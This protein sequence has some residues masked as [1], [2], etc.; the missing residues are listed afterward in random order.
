[1]LNRGGMWGAEWGGGRMWGGHVGF[2]GGRHE[3]SMGGVHGDQGA[4]HGA[5]LNSLSL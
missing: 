1:M 3:K 5:M 4:I 2:M